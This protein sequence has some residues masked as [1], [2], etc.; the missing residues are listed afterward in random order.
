MDLIEA[1][2]TRKS[3][4]AYLP[5]P[6]SKEILQEILTIACE[7]PSGVNQQPWEFA[8]ASGTLLDEIK[9]R[10]IELLKAGEPQQRDYPSHDKPKDSVYRKR[11]VALAV[12]LYK[13]LG[14][15]RDQA[16]KRFDWLVQGAGFFGAPAAVF[17]FTDKALPEAS[18][19]IDI[20][21]AIQT[22]CLAALHYG[23]GTCIQNQGVQ[24]SKMLRQVLN[25]P[26]NKRIVTS[27]SIGYIDE[28]H[29]A[30]QIKTSREPLVHVSTWHG[31]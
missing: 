27:I 4:R 14:I 3:I 5:T 16:E 1:I 2:K 29:P 6:V 28:T 19:L 12:E 22:L 9:K 30:N 25:I 21:A 20:G 17:I 24:Y 15:E 10:N 7:A 11:Q 31:F 8:I 18:P 23:L 26:E 13:A